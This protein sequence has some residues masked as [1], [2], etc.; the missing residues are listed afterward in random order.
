MVVPRF[1][2]FPWGYRVLT[3]RWP[4]HD[5]ATMVQGAVTMRLSSLA[6]ATVMST[7]RLSL[8]KLRRQRPP[9][10]APVGLRLELEHGI[11]VA[12]ADTHHRSSAPMM[13]TKVSPPFGYQCNSGASKSKGLLQRT[14]SSRSDIGRYNNA[15]NHMYWECD[16][17]E[18]TSPQEGQAASPS[19][20]KVSKTGRLH[21]PPLGA[22]LGAG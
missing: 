1:S 3:P 13:T 19:C 21:G 4:R 20:T 5:K 6:T 15:L 2:F 7:V 8:A 16:R 10:L 22:G 17:T 18:A 11:A 9:G 14:A 12:V